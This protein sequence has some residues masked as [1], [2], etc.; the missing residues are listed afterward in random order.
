MGD[1]NKDKKLKEDDIAKAKRKSLKKL[2]KLARKSDKTIV[3]LELPSSMPTELREAANQAILNAI[4]EITD[5]FTPTI[6][7]VDGNDEPRCEDELKETHAY[8]ESKRR[9]EKL[10]RSHGLVKASNTIQSS[11][12]IPTAD[13]PLKSPPCKSCPALQLGLCKCAMKR[14]QKSA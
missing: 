14:L 3:Q 11:S 4:N 10:W 7:W 8:S 9:K 1:R 6:S 2:K 13:V 12:I 5:S